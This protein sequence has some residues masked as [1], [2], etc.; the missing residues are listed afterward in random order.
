MPRLNCQLSDISRSDILVF[1]KLL[2][3]LQCFVYKWPSWLI[4]LGW[5]TAT[6]SR[7]F[8]KYLSVFR[9]FSPFVQPSV[10]VNC[11]AG[12]SLNL[13]RLI[14][15]AIQNSMILKKMKKL[16]AN[17]QISI[18]FPGIKAEVFPYGSISRWPTQSL[19]WLKI[20]QAIDQTAV[21]LSREAVS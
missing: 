1:N 6:T 5:A 4:D 9:F 8:R 15:W 3:K 16:H 11:H 18:I 7:Q 2:L 17:S 14:T 12:V 10:E 19:L 21:I 13:S 20:D